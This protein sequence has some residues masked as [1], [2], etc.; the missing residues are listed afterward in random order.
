L[1]FL[2]D[3]LLRAERQFGAPLDDAALAAHFEVRARLAM[4]AKQ[5]KRAER[6]FLEN[7]ALTEA[8]QMWRRLGDWE[9]AL[10]LARAMVGQTKI[11]NLKLEISE[12]LY[13]LYDK[14]NKKYSFCNLNNIISSF[15]KNYADIGTLRAQYERY[16]HETSQQEKA[17]EVI[18]EYLDIQYHV[19]CFR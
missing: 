13:L 8:I 17:A 4:M 5:F 19:E 11:T 16:L 9:A 7:N 15:P 1:Y 2:K 14:E 18:R 6:I 12:A 3:T 10:E